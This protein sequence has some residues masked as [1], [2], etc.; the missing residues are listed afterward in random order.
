MDERQTER[1]TEILDSHGANSHVIFKCIDKMTKGNAKYGEWSAANKDENRNFYLELE[2]ELLDGL[3]YLLMALD[4]EKYNDRVLHSLIG[5][6][7][8]LLSY[9]GTFGETR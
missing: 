7:V 9:L 2:E 6:V 1:W 4:L 8:E 3:N 5:R